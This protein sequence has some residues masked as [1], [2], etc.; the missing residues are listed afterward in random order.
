MALDKVSL[1][2]EYGKLLGIIGH[3]G[4]GKTTLLRIMAG[5][6]KPSGGQMWFDGNKVNFTDN[7]WLRKQVSMIF[8]TPVFL[9]GDVYT[10]LAY[11]LRLR[12]TPESDIEKKIDEALKIVRLENFQSREARKLSGGE[13]QRV[14]MARALVLDPKV[15]LLD[16]PTSNLD[17]ANALVISDIILKESKNRCIVLATHDFAQIRRLTGR[18]INLENGVI[19]EEGAPR[20]IYSLTKLSENIFTGEATEKEGITYIDTGNIIINSVERRTGRT[21][22]HVRPQDIIISKGYIDTSARNCFKGTIAGLME[23]RG[24]VKLYVDIGEEFIVQVTRRS[25]IEMGLNVGMDIYIS[26]KASS[27]IN[28]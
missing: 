24:I 21:T 19:T 7:Q 15:L 20:D 2:V 4:A 13:Q 1:E 17:P 28:I 9:R 26:F 5:L 6:E 14:A 23:E 8:Q 11:G 16:E 25:Y 27:V 18:I 22:I 12:K 10:N 3:S